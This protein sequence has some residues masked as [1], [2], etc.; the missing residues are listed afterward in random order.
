MNSFFDFASDEL[1]HSGF[2]AWLIKI[3]DHNYV[4]SDH[5]RKIGL[6]FINICLE[7]GDREKLAGDD[8][9]DIEVSRELK[10]IDILATL[11][12]H[13]S[14]RKIAIIIEN[15]IDSYESGSR[16]L[17][18][19]YDKIE[20]ISRHPKR[21]QDETILNNLRDCKEKVY[22]YLK[23][24]YDIGDPLKYYDVESGR[25]QPYSCLLIQPKGEFKKINWVELYNF[26]LKTTLPENSIINEYRTWIIEKYKYY[27]DL[28]D[29]PKNLRKLDGFQNHITQ[30]KLL[31]EIFRTSFERKS[32]QFAQYDEHS[33]YLFFYEPNLWL[34][35]G[36]DNDGS[37]W[38]TL[39]FTDIELKLWKTPT[40]G[41]RYLYRIQNRQNMSSG[42]HEPMLIMKLYWFYDYQR[43]KNKDVLDD[44]EKKYH[45][46]I[47][48]YGLRNLCAETKKKSDAVEKTVQAFKLFEQNFEDLKKIELIHEEFYQFYKIKIAELHDRIDGCA[49]GKAGIFQ[50]V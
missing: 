18:S 7:K 37:A 10:H 11:A 35:P 3:A 31:H 42:K 50:Q 25:E 45:R 29:I 8:P 38:T 5:L 26:F 41:P 46:L 36:Y 17:G 30:I 32:I 6:N 39:W 19:Y 13:K 20:K 27:N 24:G 14:H 47:D 12:S 2:F 28:Q 22:I 44:L 49:P 33:H 34:F 21:K 48:N 4:V 16:Q 9:L 43:E 40:V 23:S 1:T 15:K